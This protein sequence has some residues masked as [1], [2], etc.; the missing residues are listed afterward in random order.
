MK[1]YEINLWQVKEFVEYLVERFGKENVYLTFLFFKGGKVVDEYT[2]TFA[3]DNIEHLGGWLVLMQTKFVSGKVSGFSMVLRRFR[4]EKTPE[5]IP[6]K[7]IYHFFF[8]VKRKKPEFALSLITFSQEETMENQ[9][10]NRVTGKINKPPIDEIY[11][12]SSV[13]VEEFLKGGKE[14]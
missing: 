6:Y 12:D 3:I 2:S 1:E 8:T 9:N 13:L 11:C 5:G 4:K 7:E 14:R 10:L